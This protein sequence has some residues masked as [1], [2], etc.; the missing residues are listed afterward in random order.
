MPKNVGE[1]LRNMTRM[2]RLFAASSVALLAVTGWMVYDDYARPWKRYQKEFYRIDARRTHEEIEAEEAALDRERLARLESALQEARSAMGAKSKELRAARDRLEEIGRVR[3]RVDMEFRETK[4]TLDAVKFEYEEAAHGNDPSA[5]SLRSELRELEEHLEALRVRLLELDDSKSEVEATV[6]EITGRADEI[7]E[8]IEDLT[9][10]RDRL[11][12]VLRKVAPSG[13]M[14]LATG[15]LN[16]PLLD[17]MAPSLRIRQVVLEN[18]PIDIN[19]TRIP[20]ADRCQTCHLGADRKGFEQA[21]QPFRSHSRPDLF[22]TG[23]SPHPVDRFGCTPCHAGR[24]RAVDFVHATHT[25]ASPEQ[26]EEWE[27][28][29]GWERDHYWERPMLPLDRTEAGCLKCHQGVVAVPEAPRLNRGLALVERAGCYGCHKIRGFED[30]PKVA[31][32]LTRITSKTTGEWMA[33]WIKNPKAFRPSTRMPRFFGLPNNR[34]PGDAEREDAEILG[35]VAYLESK[36]ERV[37]SPPLPGRGDVDRGERLVKTIGCLGCHAIERDE[38][39]EEVLQARDR[40][41]ALDPI[42]FLRRFGPDLSRIGGKARPEWIYQWIRD[43]HRYNPATRMPNLRLTR[44]EALDI[45]TY[46]VSLKDDPAASRRVPP[47]RPQPEARD[48][49]LMAYMTQ[50]MTP[51][52]AAARLASMSDR[53]KDVLLGERSI[54][55]Y[56]CFGCHLIPGFESTPPIGTDLSTEASKR[57]DLLYFGYV[58]IEHTAPA[59]FYQKLKHPRSFDRGKVAVFYDRLRMPQ[60]GFTD[61]EAGAIT[62]VLQ[63]LTKEKVPLESV[64]RLS[65]RDEA[66]EAGRRLIRDYNCRGCHIYEGAGGA[67][68]ESLARDFMD[69]GHSADEA[70]SLAA[71]F[72]PPILDGEG[73]KVQPDWLFSF[74]K[75]PTPIRPW[76]SVRMPT[77]GLRDEEASTLVH[78]FAAKDGRIFP[79]ET[80]AVAP[81]R[82]E[83]LR[84]ALTMFT[85]DYFDCWNCHQQG[86]RKPQGPPEGWAPDLTLA[87]RRLNPDWIERWIA[88]PQKLMPGTKMPTY[89]D[90][91]DPAGSA[92][93]DILD[94]DPG[95]QIRVLAEYVFTLGRP[96]GAAAGQR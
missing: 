11:R 86:E 8:E 16:A 38:V 74:L 3:Y 78:H 20:R 51:Q 24:G 63:A 42:G 17:F 4:S 65:A 80:F 79:F 61:D 71:S 43:P 30:R 69:E 29:Y 36:A 76:L 85:P 82:G 31:P 18:I 48:R 60:F 93:P 40:G 33:R 15:L 83:K 25:P 19:F 88:N 92:P 35:I 37:P 50:R 84:A 13:L 21:P 39:P 90:P 6:T 77:F 5:E 1:Y 59:W 9:A 73:D 54:S 27:R 22:V 26:R 28:R 12:K 81:P 41:D 75:E 57:P 7:R 87:H 52:D 44:Q 66:I 96:R 23:R 89:Y 68:R 47:V 14:R 94:G 46:L 91:E 56:G 72:S 34:G 2:N 53:E 67:I 45:T 70:R 95:E 32:P 58:P 49:A 55:R 62:L 10:E 64:R